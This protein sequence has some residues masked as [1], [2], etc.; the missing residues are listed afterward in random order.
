VVTVELVP[1]D[2]GTGLR[3]TRR[4]SGSG[5]NKRHAKAWAE[6]PRATRPAD[7][8][9]RLINDFLGR[10]YATFRNPE[11]PDPAPRF[12]VASL[13]SQVRTTAPPIATRMV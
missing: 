9:R 10:G 5:V 2:S 1:K 4:L 7:H 12:P 11:R 8:G 13:N 6:G 3:L